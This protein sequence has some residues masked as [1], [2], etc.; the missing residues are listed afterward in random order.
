MGYDDE[1]EL[2]RPCLSFWLGVVLGALLGGLLGAWCR[3]CCR[4]CSRCSR[5]TSAPT[6][7]TP[8]ATTTTTTTTT[9]TV[10]QTAPTTS[11]APKIF[12]VSH[13]TD[14]KY[15]TRS[16]CTYVR[17]RRDVREY[18]QCLCCMRDDGK[19]K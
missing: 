12:I 6:T 7:I 19:D 15:H 5:T 11:A 16:D 17:S 1:V 4:C 9:T 18:E 10:K 8:S 2:E 13:H 14:A 3:D